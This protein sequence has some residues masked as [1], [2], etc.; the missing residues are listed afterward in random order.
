LDSCATPSCSTSFSTRRIDTPN[1]YEVAT[2]DTMADL[3]EVTAQ[4][5]EHVD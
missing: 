3:L 5:F 2:T 1:R 4:P